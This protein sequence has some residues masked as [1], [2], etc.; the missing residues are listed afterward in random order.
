VKRLIA[1]R[2]TH[3]V[4]RLADIGGHAGKVEA[5]DGSAFAASWDLADGGRLTLAANLGDSPATLPLKEAGAQIFAHPDH[6][7]EAYAQDAMPPWSVVA[8]VS[9]QE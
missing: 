3:I 9:A 5:I 7:D 6:A 1:A 4:P 8:S 2:M